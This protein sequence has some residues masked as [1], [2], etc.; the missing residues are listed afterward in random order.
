MITN[1]EFTVIHSLYAQGHSI[2]SIAK[3]TGMDRRTIS[4]RLKE[5]ELK[6]YKRRVYKSKLNLYK[7]YIKKR[8]K[9][10]LPHKIPSSVIYAEIQ[11]RGY[12]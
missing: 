6:P 11:D 10:A 1:E 3:I 8:L 2:R 7:E 5:Q 9:E 4:K 12:I